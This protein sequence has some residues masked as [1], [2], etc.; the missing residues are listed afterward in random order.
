MKIIYNKKETKQMKQKKEAFSS[1]FLKRKRHILL[2]GPMSRRIQLPYQ[3]YVTVFLQTDLFSVYLFFR[4]RK[5]V[6]VQ[7]QSDVK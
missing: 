1:S 5:A 7:W 4:E 3:A 6:P 2:Q